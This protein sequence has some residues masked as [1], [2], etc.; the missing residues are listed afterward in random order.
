MKKT[1][2][3]LLLLLVLVPLIIQAQV[4]IDPKLNDEAKAL[5][6]KLDSAPTIDGSGVEWESLPWRLPGFRLLRVSSPKTRFY[7]VHFQA[8]I[9][10]SG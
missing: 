5:N 3:Q 8:D 2:L 4:F 10:S 9:F 6:Y 1:F 7:G